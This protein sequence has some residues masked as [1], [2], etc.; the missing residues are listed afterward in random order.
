MQASLM[1]AGFDDTRCT[2]DPLS[3]MFLEWLCTL[4]VFA[5]APNEVRRR[6]SLRAGADNPK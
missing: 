2:N 1:R 6:C 5:G 3:R 4:R